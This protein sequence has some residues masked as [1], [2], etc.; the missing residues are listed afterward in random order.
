[1]YVIVRGRVSKSRLHAD[2]SEPVGVQELGPSEV[3]GELG[4]LD[5]EPGGESVIALEETDTITLSAWALAET[6]LLFP[7][8]AVGLLSTLSRH[9]RSLEDLNSRAWQLRPAARGSDDG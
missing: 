4:L 8:L 9:V 5:G 1:M 6:L 3:V 2:L 7:V